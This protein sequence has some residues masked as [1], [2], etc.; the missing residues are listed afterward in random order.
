MHVL[1]VEDDVRLAEALA[2][3]LEDNGYIVD[4][5]HDGQA[6]IDYGR[7]GTYDVIILDVM[8][9]KVDGFAVAQRLRGAPV[10]SPFL[11]GT[12][13]VAPPVSVAGV[14]AGAAE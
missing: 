11:R 1:V 3:I 13:R 8:L 4:T 2:R 7:S 14:V 12:A 6:G 9:P 10:G 5:V